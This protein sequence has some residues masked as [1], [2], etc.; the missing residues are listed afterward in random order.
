MGVRAALAVHPDSGKGAAARIAGTVAARLRDHV[1]RLD[2]VAANTVEQSR[3]LMD[4]SHSDG[5]DA[6]VVLGGDGAAHQAVQ[7]CARTGV[8]LGLVPCGTGNDLAR[9]LGV[10][11]DPIDAVDAVAAALREGRRRRLDLGTVGDT[12]FATVLCAGFDAAV[13]ERANRMRWPRGPRRYDLAILA[14][15]ASFRARTLVVDSDTG[16]VELPAVL[17]A[18]GNTRY[19]GGGVP[20]CPEADP[21]DGLFD[22]TV[23]GE[24]TRRELVRMLPSLR[25]GAHLDHPAVT[26]LRARR[27]TLSGGD[28][29][30]YADG[31]SLGR[32]PVSVSCVPRALAVLG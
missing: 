22:V 17:V 19:Y 31:E 12:W 5:L 29:P 1:E 8:A 27:L 25:T 21:E 15:L 28:W 24:A 20:I 7:F 18:V 30:V 3:L 10:P 6:L 4:R 14:E 13:N 9:A 2:L 26:T 11:T 23:V 16:R 32:L